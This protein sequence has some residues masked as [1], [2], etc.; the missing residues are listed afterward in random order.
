MIPFEGRAK[1]RLPFCDIF[2]F[3]LLLDV[4]QQFRDCRIY[5]TVTECRFSLLNFYET[6]QRFIFNLNTSRFSRNLIL[7]ISLF[8]YLESFF[9][10]SPRDFPRFL[11]K[12][13]SQSAC[14]PFL[15]LEAPP[16]Q[17]RINFM[18]LSSDVMGIN[19]LR[20]FLFRHGRDSN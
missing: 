8:L 10:L 9:A 14:F 20:E 5:C 2:A 16:R 7:R 12:G 11:S 17:E 3:A 18:V 6:Q 13:G 1:M 19:L 4:F 15:A